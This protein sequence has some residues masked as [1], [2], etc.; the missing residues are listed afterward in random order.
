[1]AK[2]N[3][4]LLAVLAGFAAAVLEAIVYCAP[5]SLVMVLAILAVPWVVLPA[6]LGY[7]LREVSRWATALCAYLAWAAWGVALLF[8]RGVVSHPPTRLWKWFLYVLTGGIADVRGGVNI[9]APLWTYVF[10]VAVLIWQGFFAGCYGIRALD[11]AKAPPG[12]RGDG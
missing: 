1:V 3:A 12:E 8:V 5:R 9:T 11:K 2:V 4:L 7:A 10:I 6:F